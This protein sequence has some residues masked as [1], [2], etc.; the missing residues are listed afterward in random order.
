VI[1]HEPSGGPGPAATPEPQPRSVPP[2]LP[3]APLPRPAPVASINWKA[4]RP[5]PLGAA[6]VITNVLWFY[7]PVT[8][9]HLS[10][11]QRLGLSLMGLGS[12]LIALRQRDR[13]YGFLSLALF[14]AGPVAEGLE[15][16]ASLGLLALWVLFVKAIG[17]LGA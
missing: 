5:T 3:P 1:S 10:P 15:L 14:V 7:L 2:P 4:L 12:S 17:G 6:A 13:V 11:T 9:C 16:V 8:G